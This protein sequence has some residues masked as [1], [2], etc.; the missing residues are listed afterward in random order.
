MKV[1]LFAYQTWGHHVLASLLRSRHDVVLVATHPPGEDPYETIWL[2][3]VDELARAH[4]IPVVVKRRPDAELAVRLADAHADVMVASNWRTWIPPEIFTV[5]RLGA[6]NVHDS[7]LP[8]YAG[9]A[10]LNWALINGEPEV[11]VTVHVMDAELDRGDIVHQIRVPVGRRDTAVDLFH[12]TMPLF[13][14]ITLASLDELEHGTGERIPQDPSKASFFHKR[15]LEDSRIDWTWPAEDLANLVRAQAG[16][17]PN[18][19][20]FFG[21]QRIQV[22]SAR[23]SRNRCGG[24]PGRLFA[25]EGDGVIVVCGADARRGRNHGLVLEDVRTDD[26]GELAAGELFERMGGYLTVHPVSGAVA[27]PVTGSAV[28]V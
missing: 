7:L 18:A 15:S 21:E 25:R 20:T 4:A 19:F 28:A 14:P 3:S 13:G 6:L 26:D 27:E 16:P 24:T 11:G 22:L 1:V 8:A 12:K 2:D 9:F 10:P 17:Y 23:V 5:P